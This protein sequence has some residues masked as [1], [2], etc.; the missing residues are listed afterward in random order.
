MIGEAQRASRTVDDLMELSSIE[1]GG[2]LEI[3][4]VRAVDAA[5]EAVDRVAAHA[6]QRNI[7]V[8]VVA[9]ERIAE[10]AD[11][12]TDRRRLVSALVNI[13]ENAIKYS[14]PSSD[15][16]VAVDRI[17]EQPDRTVTISVADEGVGIPQRDLDRIFERFYRVD[18]A[19]SRATG[20]TGLGLAIVRNTLHAL[21]GSVE[22]TSVE[23]EGSTFTVSLPEASA[24][25]PRA[26]GRDPSEERAAGVAAAGDGSGPDGRTSPSRSPRVQHE[27]AT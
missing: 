13:V 2:E 26:G 23:G 16:R 25:R 6:A 20:G 4:R 7:N 5:R 11:L 8:E 27:G 17:G 1:I 19:R 9:T 12:D 24:R 3:E 10:T 14:P 15:V 21:G 18:R 22:V